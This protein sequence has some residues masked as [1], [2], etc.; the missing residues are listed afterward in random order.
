MNGE[1][2]S[3]DELID[4]FAWEVCNGVRTMLQVERHLLKTGW[5]EK[6]VEGMMRRIADRVSERKKGN[7]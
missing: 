2:Y 4:H 6:A 1:V 5:S 3:M 7:G